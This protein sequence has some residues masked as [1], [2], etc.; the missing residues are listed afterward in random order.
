MCPTP[1]WFGTKLLSFGTKF[2]SQWDKVVV[3]K[4][5]GALFTQMIFGLGSRTFVIAP[6]AVVNKSLDNPRRPVSH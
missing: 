5:C 2:L 3:P 6:L 1:R 4:S